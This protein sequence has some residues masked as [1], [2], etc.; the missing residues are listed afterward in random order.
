MGQ[1]FRPKHI[2]RLVSE[3]IDDQECRLQQGREVRRYST[4]QP[5]WGVG[6]GLRQRQAEGGWDHQSSDP[7]RAVRVP[8]DQSVPML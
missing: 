5:Y 2:F 6:V 1:A 3:T 8:V 4:V 7:S